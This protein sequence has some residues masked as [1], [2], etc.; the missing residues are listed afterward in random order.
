[1]DMYA[2]TQKRASEIRL[3]VLKIGGFKLPRMQPATDDF[4]FL[5]PAV[6]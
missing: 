3:F 5:G 6:G 1:M 2:N 4:E